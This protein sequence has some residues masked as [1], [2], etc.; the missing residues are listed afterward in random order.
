MAR[1]LPKYGLGPGLALDLP[2]N[3]ESGRPYDFGDKR[4]REKAELMLDAQHVTS[5][6]QNVD[7]SA[8]DK[9]YVP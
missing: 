5:N 6:E 4:Q 8:H 9:S 1:R 3:D 2:V 7:F